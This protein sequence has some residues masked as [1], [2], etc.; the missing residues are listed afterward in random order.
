MID[1]T[2]LT[3][4]VAALF[5]LFYVVYWNSKQQE[6]R[7]TRQAERD[8]DQ[9]KRYEALLEKYAGVT[10]QV[11]SAIGEIFA[12][13]HEARM[14]PEFRR[15]SINNR[16][17]FSVFASVTATLPAPTSVRVVLLLATFPLSNH[18]SQP[19]T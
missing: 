12:G 6:K 13:L 5:V 1:W 7:D 10:T 15:A 16:R 11:I 14:L 9:A 17:F 3:V 2:Q 8:T 18:P 4:A 19:L